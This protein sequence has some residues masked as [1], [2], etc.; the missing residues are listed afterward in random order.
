VLLQGSLDYI[1]RALF[2]PWPNPLGVKFPAKAVSGE[3]GA[4]C[5]GSKTTREHGAWRAALL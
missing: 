2:T 4:Q 5:L 3:V 1:L